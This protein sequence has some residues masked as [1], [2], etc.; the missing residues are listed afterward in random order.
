[1][2]KI[3]MEIRTT[4]ETLKGQHKHYVEIKIIGKNYCVFE[5]TSSYDKTS[6]KTKKTTKYLGRIVAGGG[7]VPA[8]HRTRKPEP[9]L[10]KAIPDMPEANEV[11]L[12]L[13]TALS[14][15]GRATYSLLGKLSGMSKNTSYSQTKA[16]EKKYGINYILE[17]D[18]EKLGYLGFIT[19]IKFRGMAPHSAGV[20][21]ALESQPNV[22]FAAFVSGKYDMIIYSLARTNKEFAFFMLKLRSLPEF[23]SLT[24]KWYS[25]SEFADYNFIPVRDRFFELLKERVWHR[26]REKPRPDSSDLTEKEYTVL[27]EL[28]SNSVADFTDIDNRHSLGAGTARYTYQ[29]LKN[30]E[31]I[32]RPTISMSRIHSKFT[33]IFLLEQLLREKFVKSR[34]EFLLDVVNDNKEVV[35]KYLYISDVNI[36]HGLMIVSE[37][38]NDKEFDEMKEKLM[39]RINGIKL[40]ELIITSPILGSFCNRKFDSLHSYQ[41]KLLV[42][43]YK[44]IK[45]REIKKYEEIETQHT[46]AIR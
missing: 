35:S 5:S 25:T 43:E 27:R 46:Y 4:L 40:D 20:I 39:S 36:P 28:N 42:N 29:R 6:R 9:T 24:S 12:K 11:E 10:E 13:I 33:A 37:I 31:I 15:N 23:E 26:T 22:Q 45:P 21:K 14:M 32:K 30:R 7:F 17:I 16:L 34:P 38:F 1:M 8:K 2:Q 18:L 19:F 3:P 44:K 41:Y